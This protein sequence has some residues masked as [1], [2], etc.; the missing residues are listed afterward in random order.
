VA[1]NITQVNQGASQTETASSQVLTS[2]KSLA[3][4]SGRL[5]SKVATF[6]A[7]VRAA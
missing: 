5:K 6:L 4:E 2:A 7:T 1:G 3:G